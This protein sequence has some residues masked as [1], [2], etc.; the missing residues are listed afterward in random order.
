[1]GSEPGTRMR[2][3]NPERDSATSNIHLASTV[4]PNY[5][6]KPI[7]VTK[8]GQNTIIATMEIYGSQWGCMLV[9]F[10]SPKPPRL[11]S[12]MAPF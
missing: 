1:M 5:L 8:S 11:R 4:F 3:S 2:H 9:A 12:S 6:K 10:L 7:G